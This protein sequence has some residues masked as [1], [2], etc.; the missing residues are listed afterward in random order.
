MKPVSRNTST[1]KRGPLP[2]MSGDRGPSRSLIF[3][4]KNRYSWSKMSRASIYNC[5]DYRLCSLCCVVETFEKELKY[6]E[7]LSCIEYYCV[8]W[9]YKKSIQFVC[10]TWLRLSVLLIIIRVFGLVVSACVVH[11]KYATLIWLKVERSRI[12]WGR[13]LT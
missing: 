12:S 9:R 5:I 4:L 3:H 11:E 2:Y 8:I 1:I 6:D 7:R 10:K 13:C